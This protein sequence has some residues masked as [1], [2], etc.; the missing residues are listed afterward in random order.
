MMKD[1]RLIF[2]II[3]ELVIIVLVFSLISAK[4]VHAYSSD[5]KKILILNSYHSSDP[6]EE[7]IIAGIQSELDKQFN[8]IEYEIEY[9]GM[10]KGSNKMYFEK[11][12]EFYEVKFSRTKFDLIIACDNDAFNFLNDYYSDL[13]R[14]TPV[15]L[16]G[17]NNFKET[18]IKNREF[19]TGVSEEIDI[20]NT[21]DIALRLH[22]DTESVNIV[23][24]HSTTGEAVKGII[25][26]II[27][28]YGK[29]IKFNFLQ[30]SSVEDIKERLSRAD[31][32]GIVF[33]FGVF[34]DDN[35][36][37][38]PIKEGIAE[39]C[40]STTLPVYSCWDFFLGNGIIGGVITKG[41]RQG[42]L[43]AQAAARV[44]Q[45]EKPANIPIVKEKMNSYYF[46]YNI[47][48]RFNIKISSLPENSIVINK[49]TFPYSLPKEFLWGAIVVLVLISITVMSVL[50]INMYLK[51]VSEKALIK[52]SEHFKKRAEENRMLYT[53]AIEYDKLKTEFFA[54]ISHELR[55]PLNV[56]LGSIQLFDMYAKKG[57]II[58]KGPDLDK[59]VYVM[60][61]NCFRL[62]RLVNNLIDITKI[63][64]GFFE[65]QLQNRDIVA[66]IE[67]ITLSVADYIE[68]K[69]ITLVFDT[70]LEE[71]VVACDPDKIER[72][73]LNLLSNAIKFTPAGGSIE[74]NVYDKDNWIQV[75]V[76]D[77][78]IG[79]PEDKR[80]IIFERFRQVDKSL[81]RNREGSGIGLSLTKSLVE[82]HNGK[83]NVESNLGEGTVFTF[84][85]P[86]RI[87]EN[88]DSSVEK[89]LQAEHVERISLEFSDIYL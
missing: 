35:Y 75:S 37:L 87:V 22:K 50:S 26:E 10:R 36:Q 58:Y 33:V 69:G 81:S 41:E 6:W 51:R 57:D 7:N 67:D 31:S 72:I 74:V 76:K 64:S 85:L 42:R 32:K 30:S 83:I 82:M 18:D 23:L 46:D 45:G 71:K 78:G 52:K 1:K 70:E 19:F 79:I 34:N 24:D 43:A 38:M 54:N 89:Q 68:N 3:G 65:L 60:R 63:D 61:Q 2:N 48:K 84:E 44:L 8:S 55:T 27:P 11:T 39:I 40:K 4:K 12:F 53:E 16:V 73:M 20:K 5:L 66:V 29:N 88:E 77:S 80:S 14:Q 86:I 59:K 56:L 9:L 21:I 62:L 15:V 49:P 47:L 17:V 28:F 13:F 25:E